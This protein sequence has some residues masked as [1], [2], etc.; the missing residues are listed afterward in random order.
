[1]EKD[2]ERLTTYVPPE[3]KRQIEENASRNRR[4]LAGE[5][6]FILERAVAKPQSSKPGH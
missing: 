2:R 5:A 4:S 1:M 6:A 3:V